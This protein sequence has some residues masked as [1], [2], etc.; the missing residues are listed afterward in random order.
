MLQQ[1]LKI[2]RNSDGVI[3]VRDLAQALGAEPSAVEGML[4]QLVYMGKLTVA[5]GHA[6]GEN[7]TTCNGCT[8]A[9]DCPLLFYVPKRYQ[10]VE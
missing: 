6:A 8:G 5:S 10:V 9:D 4:Q 1:I 2:L 7:C 3:S